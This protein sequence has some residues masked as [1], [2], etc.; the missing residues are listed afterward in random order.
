MKIYEFRSDISVYEDV[1]DPSLTV[2]TE[3]F[4][5]KQK[6]VDYM[7]AKALEYE[8]ANIREKFY[9]NVK[10]FSQ[11]DEEIE[12]YSSKDC[13]VLGLFSINEREV[14]E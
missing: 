6:A 11:D 3:L 2:E 10:S 14:N 12:L 4:L 7:R 5:T 8:N 13:G 9:R 1:S